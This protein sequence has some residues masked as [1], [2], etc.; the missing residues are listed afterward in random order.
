MISLKVRQDTKR[1]SETHCAPAALP[2]VPTDG[3]PL[4]ESGDVP[5]SPDGSY[6]AIAGLLWSPVRTPSAARSRATKLRSGGGRGGE[7]P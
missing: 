4:A 5:L 2:F 1:S 6:S 7:V 3:L